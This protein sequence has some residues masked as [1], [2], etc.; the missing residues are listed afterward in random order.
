MTKPPPLTRVQ[1]A[2]SPSGLHELDRFASIGARDD[3]GYPPGTELYL[4]CRHC[5]AGG[6]ALLE[7]AQVR[8]DDPERLP[9]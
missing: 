8:W 9:E 3:R 7:D 2:R 5:K 4:Q 6:R 1:C